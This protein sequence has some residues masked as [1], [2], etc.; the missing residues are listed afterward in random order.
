MRLRTQLMLTFAIVAIV[1]LTVV[2][3]QGYFSSE[4][5]YRRAVE[6]EAETLAESMGTEMERFTLELSRRMARLL[7]QPKPD[8]SEDY[9]KARRDA[10]AQ[11]ERDQALDTLQG[12]LARAEV[13]QGEI[14]FGLDAGGQLIARHATDQPVLNTFTETGLRAP[15]DPGGSVQALGDWIVVMRRDPASGLTLGIARPV[16]AELRDIREAALRNLGYGLAMAIAALL[17]IR[18]LSRRLTRNLARVTEGAERLA[19]G[20]LTVRVPVRSKDELGELAESF[21]R[22][23]EDLA[24]H[25]LEL[26]RRE[27]LRRELELCQRIQNE[28]LPRT[29]LRTLTAEVSG[30][31]VA[32]RAVGGDFYNYF[33]LPDGAL[34]VLVGDVSGK[35]VPAALLMANLQA[36]LRARLISRRD[37]ARV[38]DELDHEIAASTNTGHYLTLF[39]GVVDPA[40]REL[41]YLNAGHAEPVLVATN[42]ERR[43]LPSTG[44]PLALLPGGGYEVGRIELGVGGALC[45]FTDGL[46]EA[47]DPTGEELGEERLAEL[48]VASRERSVDGMLAHVQDG[49]RAFRGRAEPRDDATLVVLKTRLEMPPSAAAKG[50]ALAT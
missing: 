23:A 49:V 8:R 26:V 12:V 25:Q 37:L 21:N 9:E 39:A 18:P 47:E 32:A 19:K 50:S 34:V 28:F 15:T 27:S 3:L 5:S 48:L 44:R 38:A 29:S 33:R 1:P 24:L 40:G 22:M 46:S 42:G 10:L 31:S 2:T 11:A 7:Q 45:A 17:T 41:R 16:G 20:D 30:W 6:A 35:G 4:G 13:E 14:P 43:R 36:T